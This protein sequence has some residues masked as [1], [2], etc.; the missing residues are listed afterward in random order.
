MHTSY[1]FTDRQGLWNRG[2]F[3]CKLGWV[4]VCYI[5]ELWNV[6]RERKY[7]ALPFRIKCLRLPFPYGHGL[8]KC[9]LILRSTNQHLPDQWLVQERN[10]QIWFLWLFPCFYDLQISPLYWHIN[11]SCCINAFNNYSPVFW[12]FSLIHF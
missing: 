5:N 4:S 12:D 10:C 1:L 2:V 6:T 8:D 9:T 3:Q 11:L 7:H